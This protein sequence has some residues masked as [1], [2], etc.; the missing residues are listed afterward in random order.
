MS[1]SLNKLSA[2]VSA[3]ESKVAALNA[4]IA[5]EPAPVPAGSEVVVSA[6]L[7]S[8]ADRL[9]AL[10][11]PPAPAPADPAPAAPVAS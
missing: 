5:G 4:Q 11:N 2:A 8:L 3:V 6:D 7:D 10:V 1:Q 9:N